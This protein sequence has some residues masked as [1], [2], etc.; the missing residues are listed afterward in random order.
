MRFDYLFHLFRNIS[1]GSFS[2]N[3]TIFLCVGLALAAIAFLSPNSASATLLAINNSSF[4]S[5]FRDGDGSSGDFSG[6]SLGSTNPPYYG[7]TYNPYG[8]E[9]SGAA[10]NGTPLGADGS[11]VALLCAYGPGSNNTWIAQVTPSSDTVQAGDYTFTV[12]VGWSSLDSSP[13]AYEFVVLAWNESTGATTELATIT[14]ESNLL[15]QG[16]FT[17]VS[18]DFDVAT[19]NSHIGERF[20]IS[21]NAVS[22]S[23]LES[24]NEGLFVDNV[25]LD[26]NPIPEP[27]ALALVGS[28][29][30]ALL[31]Y[32]WRKRR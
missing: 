21:L 13:A 12:A 7:I 27:N 15:T 6:W 5:P 11:N 23:G 32:A 31:C 8:S 1:Q 17:D 14:G 29:L 3:R 28:G 26:Y 18:V 2:M 30:F 20:L 22:H 25:R 10:E 9:F 24:G 4:E 16:E 19:G